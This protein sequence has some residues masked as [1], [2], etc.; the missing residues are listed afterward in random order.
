MLGNLRSPGSEK[1]VKKGVKRVDRI[2][3]G[4]TPFAVVSGVLAAIPMLPPFSL[5]R[6][7]EESIVRLS[8]GERLWLGCW[9]VAFPSPVRL[10]RHLP[11][12]ATFLSIRPRKECCAG[13]RSELAKQR[14]LGA[15]RLRNVTPSAE[16]FM[17]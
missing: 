7:K 12:F 1:V 5:A 14:G 17:P 6:D 3:S 15:T 11:L 16:R 10:F 8:L 4:D 9:V 13:A 2:T